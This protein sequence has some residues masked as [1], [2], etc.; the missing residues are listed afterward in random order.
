MSVVNDSWIGADELRCDWA[1]WSGLGDGGV[2]GFDQ[3]L[4]N[5][6]SR[7]DHMSLLGCV[8]PEQREGSGGE[9][10]GRVPI[11][12]L[13]HDRGIGQRKQMPVA[14]VLPSRP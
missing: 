12:F 11:A 3:G 8:R 1:D 9:E 4:N 7:R 2:S 13:P 5:R 6:R 10:R 14:D